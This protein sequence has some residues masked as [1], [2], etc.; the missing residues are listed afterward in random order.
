MSL[1]RDITWYTAG[2][3][4]GYPQ[5]NYPL[6]LSVAKRLREAGYTVVSPAEL[7]TPKMQA[8][9]MASKD[10]SLATMEKES[11]ETWGDVLARDVKLISDKIG[12]IIVLPNWFL[13]RGARL[14]VFVGLLTNKQ[15]AWWDEMIDMALPLPRSFIQ[16]KIK[17]N[18][19]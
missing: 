12:G 5:F 7:D 17:E 3:M 15:F 9:A 1:D 13:S 6:F 4:T 2:G 8:L 11:G 10:G 14:E 18:M 19:P 16:M